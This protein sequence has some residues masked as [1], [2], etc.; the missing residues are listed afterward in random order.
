[1]IDRFGLLPDPV[2]NLFRITELKQQ[3]QRIGI[4]KL[5]LGP[6]GGRVHFQPQPNIDPMTI[7]QLIQAQPHRYRMD[8]GD[9]LKVQQPMAKPEQRFQAIDDLFSKL[10][11]TAA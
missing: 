3:A 7:I 8:G 1:M 2:K 6:T 11:R 4:T 9:K 5:D 10:N